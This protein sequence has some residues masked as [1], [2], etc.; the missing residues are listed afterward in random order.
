MTGIGVKVRW[1]V[2]PLWIAGAA[3]GCSHGFSNCAETRTC[4]RASGGSLA[5]GSGGSSQVGGG[6][7]T[8]GAGSSAPLTVIGAI[9]EICAPNGTYACANRAQRGR[10][11]CAG[12]VW[13][14][15]G[16][17]DPGENCDSRAG[18]NQGF[19]APIAGDC[20]AR[21]PGDLFCQL[22]S[23]VA[24]GPDLLSVEEREVC[25]QACVLGT[26]TECEINKKQCKDN[27]VQTCSLNGAWGALAACANQA[28]VDGACVG[29]CSPGTAQCKDNGVQTCDSNGAWGA[30]VACTNQA[31]VTDQCKGS[32]VP[33]TKR[34][35][36]GVEETCDSKGAWGAAQACSDSAPVCSPEGCVRSP[37]CIGL[38][39]TCGSS[40]IL[41]CCESGPLPAG[42]Y[43]RPGTDAASYPVT[44]SEFRLDKYEVTVGRFRKFMTA[45]SQNMISAGAGKNPNNA[46]DHGWD[47]VWNSSL[48]PSAALVRDALKS[49]DAAYTTW[50]DFPGNKESY[51]INCVTWYEAQAFCTWDQG[52]L[53]T[54]A[55]WQYARLGGDELRAYPWGAQAPDAT[56]VVYQCNLLGTG[57][58]SGI[59]DIARVGSR[60]LG[61]GKWKQSD[62]LG[63][64][65]EWNQDYWVYV[66][67]GEYPP[68]S[69]TNCASLTPEPR[70]ASRG[71]T[72]ETPIVSALTMRGGISPETRSRGQ[73]I[74][75]AR[76]H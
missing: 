9:G 71:G 66:P 15:N 52:R 49:C 56:R 64:V 44:L 46:D 61:D 25:T 57:T 22:K 29:V 21:N 58:C 33:A 20:T 5:S 31:C 45:Y 17:C 19:C 39:A 40:G 38:P 43:N 24:C 54:E 32:C 67:S 59:S 6:G 63:N 34:C 12:G 14:S 8:G 7:G 11:V 70:R 36:N 18:A 37:S 42:T 50:E 23:K 41:E 73:G 27:G 76:S 75:C 1:W 26:C 53:P 2:G 74:R 60:P 4:A 62:L 3:S 48:A 35:T 28:C 65:M 72:F 13:A 30:A 16:S 55:E 47:I 10:L 69:C 68:M 51:P